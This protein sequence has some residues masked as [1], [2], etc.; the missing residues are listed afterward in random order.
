MAHRAE[1]PD[2]EAKVTVGSGN[3]FEDIGFE[4]ADEMLYK[5]KLVT[6]IAKT[7]ERIGMTQSEAAQVTGVDQPTLSKLLRGRTTKFSSDR[8]C[9]ML[10]SLG[11][12]VEIYVKPHQGKAGEQGR[13]TV[14]IA[15]SV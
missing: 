11:Q 14:S 3:V 2:R 1:S 15:M 9:R 10:A 6:A 13:V 12:D 5:S 8:L 4:N 7:I